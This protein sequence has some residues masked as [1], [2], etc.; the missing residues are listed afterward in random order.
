MKFIFKLNDRISKIKI[1]KYIND[2][3][4]NDNDSDNNYNINDSNDYDN[5]NDVK[6][7]FYGIEFPF[8]CV[9]LLNNIEY[10]FNCNEKFYFSVDLID[11]LILYTNGNYINLLYRNVKRTYDNCDIINKIQRVKKYICKIHDDDPE[12]C[13]IYE[14]NGS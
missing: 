9:L 8:Y 3:Y 14:C 13:N 10:K 7:V 2:L 12:I 11:E 5:Y 6:K 4:D 1:K